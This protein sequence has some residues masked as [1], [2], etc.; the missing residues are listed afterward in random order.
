M[1]ATVSVPS[2]FKIVQSVQRATS[3]KH[4]Q[5]V[6]TM[7]FEKKLFKSHLFLLKGTVTQI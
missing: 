7:Q 6:K 5:A 1:F 3:C 2:S 4:R